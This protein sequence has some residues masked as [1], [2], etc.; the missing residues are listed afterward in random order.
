MRPR[1]TSREAYER[2]LDAY[3]RMTPAERSALAL[4]MSDEMR[5]ISAEGI[6]RRHPDYSEAE[7]RRALVALLYGRDVS[8]K[9]WPGLPVPAP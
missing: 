8:S 5:R 3:R 7:V 4:E 9:V 2:Q 1:D 6:Q